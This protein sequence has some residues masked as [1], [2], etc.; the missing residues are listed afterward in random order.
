MGIAAL[1]ATWNSL[2]IWKLAVGALTPI[3]VAILGIMVDRASK[4]AETAAATAARLAE[5]AQWAN[6]RAVERL[7]ELHKEI[8]PLLNDMLCFFTR[9]GH[10]REIDPPDMLAR[11]RKLDHIFF[12]NEHLFSSDL[13][14]KYH[15]LMQEC[16]AHWESFGQDARMRT[17]AYALRAERGAV[18]KWDNAWTALFAELHDTR[19]L[20]RAQRQA[21][22]AVM[23]AF[24][25][26]LGISHDR[27][28]KTR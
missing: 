24:A 16:F 22:E 15:A 12:V 21:Y 11:K 1:D 7:I 4:R 2:E 25:A 14:A 19:E 17:S 13:R 27:D 8:A 6:R 10:F 5:N 23:L 18:A 3:T 20:T 26:N 28:G 9:V